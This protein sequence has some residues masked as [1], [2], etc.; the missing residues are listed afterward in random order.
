MK[1]G[2]SMGERQ[3]AFALGG[4]LTDGLGLLLRPL[5]PE[6]L[7]AAARRLAAYDDFGDQVFLEPMHRLL[8]ACAREADLNVLGWFVTRWDTLRFLRNLLCLRRAEREAPAIL[9]ERI[10]APLFITGMPRSGTSFLHT[11]LLQDTMNRAVPVWQTLYPCASGADESTA[12][13]ARVSRQLRLF[14]RLAPEFRSLHPLEATSLQECSEIMAHVFTS[15]RFDMTY[16]VPSYRAWLDSTGYIGA[17]QFHQRFLQHLQY[18]T[19]RGK[20]WVLKCPDHVFAL[21][22]IRDVYPDA[23]VVFVHRDPLKVLASITCLTEVVRR[24][25]TRA[26]DLAELGAEQ[27]QRWQEGAERMIAATAT[28]AFATPIC[29]VQHTELIRDPVGTVAAI[30]RHFGRVL[31]AAAAAAMLGHVKAHPRGGYGEH[32]YRIERYGLDP[33]VERERFARYKAHFSVAD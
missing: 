4:V 17:Y 28:S 26:I 15:L 27:S 20:S 25:F 11:M 33:E 10:V 2:E 16:R 12:A 29:H 1:N 9:E 31:P 13:I 32:Q 14:E 23:R 21:D 22:A 30:Y 6:R 3:S 18:R 8:D 19:D 7:L 5:Q 24:P